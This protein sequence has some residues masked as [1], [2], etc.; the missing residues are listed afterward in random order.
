LFGTGEI[1]LRSLSA[2]L[3]TATV[4][5]AYLA[6][7][8]LLSRTAGVVLAWLAAVSPFMVWY[9]QDARSYALFTFLATLSIYLYARVRTEPRPALVAAWA[10]VCAASIWTHYFA[11]YVVVTEALL[12]VLFVPRARRA[13]AAALVAIALVSLPAAA[14]ATHQRGKGSPEWIGQ[15]P[16]TDRIRGGTT[17]FVAGHYH[18]AHSRVVVGLLAAA[19]LVLLAVARSRRDARGLAVAVCLAAAIL[20][21]P[22]V[23]AALGKDYV[24]ARNV[25]PAWVCAAMIVAVGVAGVGR[26]WLTWLLTAALVALSLVPT[27]QTFARHEFQ[28]KD[29]RGLAH[30]LGA[31]RAD[32]ALV[33]RSE[34][35]ALVLGLY[36]P[37]SLLGRRPEPVSE[38]VVVDLPRP[39]V[40]VPARFADAGTACRATIPVHRYTSKSPVR[41]TAHELLVPTR[42]GEGEVRLDRPSPSTP[43]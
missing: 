21:L 38:I 5:V 12:L 35:P 7:A 25:M 39:N 36:R 4:A 28:R 32:R 37:T 10:C 14:L 42:G 41:L 16:L 43:A 26:R 9:S 27:L 24:L 11:V 17:E 13:V 1:G 33:L 31:Y 2:L 8:R 29:W 20:V 30:C 6:G 18:L 22:L 19:V 34:A 15:L 23:A 40:R 3:G